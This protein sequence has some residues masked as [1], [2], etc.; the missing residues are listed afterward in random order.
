MKVDGELKKALLN[1]LRKDKEK[2]NIKID[3]KIK[4]LEE[5]GETE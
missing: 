5:T 2:F 4:R 3:K 1:I